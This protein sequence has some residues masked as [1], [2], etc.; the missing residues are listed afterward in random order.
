[1]KCRNQVFFIS[2]MNLMFP[3]ETCSFKANF[4]SDCSIF[5]L[6]TFF[7]FI[8]LN[9]FTSDAIYNCNLLRLIF[10]N[11]QN[12][13]EKR[14]HCAAILFKGIFREKTLTFCDSSNSFKVITIKFM[15]TQSLSRELVSIF[16]LI[17]SLLIPLPAFS[18]FSFQCQEFICGPANLS[19]S[20]ST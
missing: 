13:P 3:A 14:S 8:F 18:L 2:K 9:N 19:L 4:P 6:I 16:I 1:M 20:D 7:H 17:P 12:I 5:P 11:R 10:C 15:F